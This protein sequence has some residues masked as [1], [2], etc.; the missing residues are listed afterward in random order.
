MKRNTSFMFDRIEILV[1][2]MN[3]KFVGKYNYKN[4][5]ISVAQWHEW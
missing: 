4:N 5:K 3:K 2:K 1:F